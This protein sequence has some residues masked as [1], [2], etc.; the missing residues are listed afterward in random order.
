[1]KYEGPATG[2]LLDVLA[3][4][5]F[6]SSGL[7]G[8]SSGGARV[9]LGSLE[10]YPGSARLASI[11]SGQQPGTLGAGGPQGGF[12][13]SLSPSTKAPILTPTSMVERVVAT[14]ESVFD[15]VWSVSVSTGAKRLGNPR[16]EDIKFVGTDWRP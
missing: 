4:V 5:T 6:E 1:M 9:P 11:L 15:V 2:G 16:I 3:G 7:M 12:G 14:G 8:H 10:Q 13:V